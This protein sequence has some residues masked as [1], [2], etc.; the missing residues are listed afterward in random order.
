MSERVSAEEAREIA[1]QANNIPGENGE[2][3]W[4]RH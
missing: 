2:M 1:E 4:Q 3:S